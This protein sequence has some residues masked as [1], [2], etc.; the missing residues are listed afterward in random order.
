MMTKVEKIWKQCMNKILFDIK[1]NI[2][3]MSKRTN[4]TKITNEVNR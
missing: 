2:M 3:G 1:K 4:K